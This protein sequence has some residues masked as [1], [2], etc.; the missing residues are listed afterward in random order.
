MTRL[1]FEWAV[2]H[3]AKSSAPAAAGTGTLFREPISG[4]GRGS[5]DMGT[6]AKKQEFTSRKVR[7]RKTFVKPM[8]PDLSSTRSSDLMR[9]DGGAAD[10]R[11]PVFSP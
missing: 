7:F 2:S 9:P 3:V 1:E 4:P 5:F 11:L 8:G 10:E 6:G